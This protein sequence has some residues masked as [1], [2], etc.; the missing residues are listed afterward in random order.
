MKKLFALLAVLCLCLSLCSSAFAAEGTQLG[1]TMPAFEVTDCRGELVSLSGLLKDHQAVLVNFF[2]CDCHWCRTE[3]PWLESAWEKVQD[4][5]AVVALTPYDTSAEA[6][7][8][9]DELGLKF[10]VCE[11]TIGLAERFRVDGFPTS[12]LIDR[13]GVICFAE[14]GYR[15]EEE[16]DALFAAYIGDD[17]QGPVFY[18]DEEKITPAADPDALKKALGGDSAFTFTSGGD[19]DYSAF[20]I[21]EENEQ[22]T[23]EASAE[24]YRCSIVTADFSARAGQEVSFYAGFLTMDYEGADFYAVL[25]DSS[26]YDIDEAIIDVSDYM[27]E[28]DLEI[29][30]DGTFRI[31]FTCWS[32]FT[33]TYAALSDI[34]LE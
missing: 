14:G 29:P 3:F 27:D 9:A 19:D 8:L 34:V 12:L 28:Y 26:G 24:E 25:Q 5:V 7:E 21:D 17:Y 16:F 30:Y 20:D 4:Q 32:D 11:D 13:S 31:E 23:F 1:D 2:Y 18:A 6:A 10:H 15:T 22:V 33:E